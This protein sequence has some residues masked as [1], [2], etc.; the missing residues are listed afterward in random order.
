M[1]RRV[2]LEVRAVL[3][4]HAGLARRAEHDVALL[5]LRLTAGAI[6]SSGLRKRS[7]P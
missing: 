2:T 4:G 7:C 1:S 3:V 5:R 6:T